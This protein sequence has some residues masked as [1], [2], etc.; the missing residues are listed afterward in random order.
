MPRRRKRQTK[1]A[2]SC[3]AALNR[4][5]SRPG[6]RKQWTNESM[7]AAL[8]AVKDGE[9]VNRAAILHGIPPSTLKDRLSG[10]VV[11][12]V[13]PGPNR[14]LDDN[15]E[16]LL[17][18]HLI[19]AAK[20]GY[21]KT[22]KQV[23][24][25]VENVAKEKGLLKVDEKVTDGWWRRFMERQPQLSLR[26]GD[27]TAHV[28]MNAVNKE[29]IDGYFDLLEETLNVHGLMN[30]PGQLYNMD[31]SGI[32][33]DSRPPNV[34]AKRGQ[35]KVRYRTA[36]NKDQ[37]T[38]IGCANAAGQSVPPMVIF[39][40][41]YLNH[42]WTVGEVPGT[43]YGMSG[44]GWTDQELF[45]HWL[46]D[47]FL[48][49]CVASRPILLLLDGHS[50][51]YEPESVEFAKK[52]NIILFCLPPH[53][54]QDSQP[55]DCT[56]FGPLKRHWSD[57]CHDFQQRHPGKVVNKLNFSSLFSQAWLK[58]LTP[59]NIM[60]GFRQCGIYPFNRNAIQIP[61]ST[62]S[63]SSK[64]VQ[65]SSIP[66]TSKEKIPSSGAHPQLN[67]STCPES[68]L[69][70][71]TPAQIERFMVRHEEGYDLYD[72]EYI[73]WLE[74]YHP[75]AL[76]HDHYTL[77]SARNL[78][79]LTEKFSSVEPL[80][81][82]D[83]FNEGTSSVIMSTVETPL[84]SESLSA[85][86]TSPSPSAAMTSP[87]PSSAMTSPSPSAAVTSPSPSAAMT[88]PSPSSAM[89]SPSPS[90]AMTSPSPSSAMTSP[91][92]SAAMTSPSP[93]A[94]MTSPS[95]SEAM[96]PS[97]PMTSVSPS[98]PMT[99]SSPSLVIAS[100]SGS[101]TVSPSSQ[102]SSPLE[103]F[104]HLPVSS[105]LTPVTKPAA[106]TPSTP[107]RP[108]SSGASSKT[109]AITSARVL[110]SAEC[111]A[112]IKEKEMK[113]KLEAEEKEQRKRER[114]EKKKQREVERKKKEEEK[115]QKEV[116]RKKKAEEK[117]RKAEERARKVVEKAKF[118]VERA[119]SKTS[120]K[121]V[122]NSKTGNGEVQEKRSEKRKTDSA[123]TSTKRLR[124]QEEVNDN[125]C[126]ICFGT[127][128]DDVELETGRDWV[129]CACGQWTHEDCI[130]DS[131]LDINGQE[132]FCPA[133]LV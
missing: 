129:Q 22:R 18:E 9:G 108:T 127:Y 13:N 11:H 3:P 35:K 96:T 103:K 122:E 34:I 75:E 8:Q 16:K 78:T 44:K 32:P 19:E 104:L 43:F 120:H 110:T 90:T 52:E 30:S 1:R 116:E 2:S 46:K 125:V 100:P 131:V 70:R 117:V 42:E 25:I 106:P 118:T 72:P 66:S 45:K 29:T 87:S 10:R 14:Y 63:E 59:V 89:T 130:D 128:Q 53:T 112:I 95:P 31:E 54:T 121:R 7:L 12:G 64:P 88:S 81:P 39:E 132:R 74:V 71:F 99:S 69:D 94:A 58:A 51:H 98:S 23:M 33:L 4:K 93:S 115:A 67:S 92:H 60:A 133:C 73:Y 113:K 21:G 83:M 24:G 55:L 36:G 111:L 126:S 91:S 6:R 109:R 41:K 37:I 82:I 56:V 105:T 62:S 47:H 84:T 50:S 40:G 61:H 114:E 76:P 85:A 86:M 27:A 79:S 15:E 101:K 77:T 57:I 124:L 20:L 49:H 97:S 26:R 38:V 123:A 65:T 80:R 48:N 5:T 17:A 102:Q 119:K 107:C 28:R 68:I